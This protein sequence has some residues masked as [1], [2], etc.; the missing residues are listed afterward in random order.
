ML[1][2][3][4]LSLMIITLSSV[5][6]L[7]V[8]MSHSSQMHSSSG[9]ATDSS[10]WFRLKCS[11]RSRCLFSPCLFPSHFT[12]EPCIVFTECKVLCKQT[13]GNPT[14]D[15]P[16]LSPSPFTG[17]LEYQNTSLFPE[18]M[19][20]KEERREQHNPRIVHQQELS[21]AALETAR[22]KI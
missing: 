4:K 7:T 8:N 9:G 20:G 1:C 12:T 14:I 21:V 2:K 5:L 11:E 13:R 10:I 18:C 15:S 19:K 17:H 3:N 16:L 6:L 22:I